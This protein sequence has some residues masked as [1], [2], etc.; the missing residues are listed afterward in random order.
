MAALSIL[1]VGPASGTSRHRYH[2]LLRLGHAVD[3]VDPTQALGRSSFLTALGFKTGYLGLEK[4]VAAHILAA[5]GSRRFDVVWVDNGEWVGPSLAKELKAR[6]TSL[7]NH[8]LD[9]PFTSRD[10]WRWRLFRK[11][12]PTY[13]LF[14]T[15]R[16]SSRAAAIAGGARRAIAVMF[17]ADERVH[18]PVDLSPE[19]QVTFGSEVAF[20]GTW[21]PERGPFMKRLVDRGVP[22]RIFG[23]RWTKAAEYPSLAPVVVSRSLGDEDYVKAVSGAKIGVGLLSKGN[24]DL[25]TTRSLEIPAIGTLLCAPRTTDHERLYEDAAEAVFFDDADGCADLCLGLLADPAR[26]LA[27]AAAGHRRAMRNG[28]FNEALCGQILA[29]L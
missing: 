24:E 23:P 5:L 6:A 29:A 25:H 27:I 14:V 9:N 13:D 7:L 4:R 18:R 10:G 21:M 20:V 2:A 12:L 3:I 16:E 22:L 8:N 28:H 17:S 15:P 26:R 11:A 19:D 1:Y